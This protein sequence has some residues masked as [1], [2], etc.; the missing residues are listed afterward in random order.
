MPLAADALVL[1]AE[2]TIASSTA[3]S[4]IDWGADGPRQA[5]T[6]DNSPVLTFAAPAGVPSLFL[7]VIQ[8]ATGSWTVTWPGTV[9][10]PAGTPPTLSTAPNAVDLLAFYFDGTN[11]LGGFAGDF[12]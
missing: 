6:L 1:N 11:Y 9:Q 2:F 3:D 8:D 7:R 10:W 12:S 4:S 5:I